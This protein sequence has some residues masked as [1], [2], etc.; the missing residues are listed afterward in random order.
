MRIGKLGLFCV[1]L[2]ACGPPPAQRGERD[3]PPQIID[4]SARRASSTAPADGSPERPFATLAEAVR[5]ARPGALV[6]LDEGQ[7]PGGLVLARPL[8]LMG[9][10]PA[11]TRIVPGPD[12]EAPLL[13]VRGTGRIE[14][15][16]LSIVGGAVGL[17]ID[18]G[19]GHLLSDVS[20]RDQT[21]T[22]LR[23]RGAE[24][25]LR[26][27]EIVD[28]AG[29]VKGFGIEATG[30]ALQLHHCVLR[31]A[32]RRA[33][34]LHGTRALLEDVDAAGSAVSALQ[35][36]DGAEVDVSGGRF[37]HQGGAAL[38]A[39]AATLR[40]TSAHLFENEYGVLG[41]RG[42][43]IDVTDSL[44]EDHA[45]AAVALVSSS[46]SVRRC[47]I[48]H[49]GIEGGISALGTT[50]VVLVE[51]TRILDPGTF[52]VHL[53]NASA[54]LRGGEISGATF[55]RQHELGDGLYAVDSTVVLQGAVLRRNQGS[56][57]SLSGSQLTIESSD[58]IGNG[59]SGLLLLDRSRATATASLFGKNRAGV[60]V[61]ELSVLSLGGSVFDAN[62]RFAIDAG[63]AA[64]GV[65]HERGNRN[66][67]VGAGPHRRAC[68]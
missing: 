61:S 39:G 64:A 23:A 15:R 1:A 58:L 19:A 52:G 38:Y 55:D 65:V 4:V 3:L 28:I 22:A 66:Q 53:T 57:A 8:V 59:R 10:G 49:G 54:I 16:G 48:F 45:V 62:A 41:F 6:R 56:G 31:R 40:V 46:G 33:I 9:R 30:G 27:S 21:D 24:F 14:L 44:L 32:G 18:G 43:R 26:G 11:R 25:S 68:P 29:G 47:T 37:A 63:C 12:A 2:T 7:Y 20:L 36:L 34:E 13:T 60:S 5:A 51:G 35:A 67:F 50:G 42:A 17:D